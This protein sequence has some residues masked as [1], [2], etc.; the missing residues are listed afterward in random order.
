MAGEETT[1]QQQSN[2]NINYNAAQTG[3]D[4]DKTLGQIP[5]GKLTYALNANV[6]NFDANSVNYQNEEGN[7]FCLE[8]PSGYTLIG[9]HYIQEKAKHIFFLVNSTTGASQI[10]YMVNNDC[11]YHSLLSAECLNFDINYPIH[12]VVHRITNCTTEIYW[13]DGLNARRFLDIDDVPTSGDICNK[14]SVQPN[15][16]I[17]QLDITEVTT[18]GELT[19]GTYQFAIQYSDAQ[20]FGYTSYY[21]VTN[22]TPIA[23]PDITTAEYNYPVNK[24]IRLTISNL[25]TSGYYE[26]YNLAVIKTVNGITSV[27]LIGTYFIDSATNQVTYTGQNQTQIRLSL[28]DIFE[29]FPYYDIAGDVTSVQ[30]ILIWDQLTT[31]KRIDYQSIA[32]Q[33]T[34]QWESYKIPAG[35]DY[36]NP[37]IANKLR[38]YLR[39]EVYAFEICFLLKNGRQT[40]GF[41]I[42]GRTAVASDL[43]VINKASNNDYIGSGTSAPTWKI[44]NTA[45]VVGNASQP[46]IAGATAYKYGDFSYWESEEDYQGTVFT[47]A[48]LTGPIRHHKFPDVLV[49]PIFESAALVGGLPV[50]QSSDAV[51]PLGVRVDIDQIKSLIASSSLTT[52]EKAEIVGFKILRGSRSTNKSIVGKGILRN[53]GKYTRE[54][55]DYYFPNYPYNDLNEDPFLLS[56]S[57]AYNSQSV[58]YVISSVTSP[59]SLSYTSCLTGQVESV[60]LTNGM[61][62]FDLCSLT[63]PQLQYGASA[64][65]TNPGPKTVTVGLTSDSSTLFNYKDPDA[66]PQSVNVTYA[67]GIKYIAINSFYPVEYALG[68]KNYTITLSDTVNAMTLPSKLNAFSTDASKFRN[69]FNSPETSFGQP[70]LGSVLKLENA[71]FGESRSHFVQVKNN[72]RYK[73][74]NRTTQQQALQSSYNIAITTGTL[75][76]NAMFTTY[77]AYLQI[78]I[79][80]LSRTNFAY[81]FNSTASYD[82]W[83]NVTNSGNKQRELS[84]YQYLIPGVQSTADD[85]DVNN[86]QRESSVYLKTAGS[87]PLPFVKD[88]P[89]VSSLSITDTTRFTISQRHNCGAPE[90]IVSNSSVMYYASLKNIVPN[91]YGQLYSYETIDTGFQV[92][93]DTT[94]TIG[95]VFGGDTFVSRFAFKTKLPFFI[96]NRVGAPDDSDIFYDEVGNIAYPR[97]WHSAR[98]ILSNYQVGSLTNLQNII[99]VKATALDCPNDPIYSAT[100]GVTTTTTTTQSPGN[101]STGNYN[102]GY[103]GKM[104]MFA[105]G[106]PYFYCE[107]SINID[108]RQAVN[109]LDGDFYPHVS[110]GIP[111]TWLQ[112][113]NVPIALDNTYNYNITFSK[114]NTENYF[115]HLPI[116]WDGNN[117]RTV[118]PFRTIYSDP[119]VSDPT[120]K[121]NNWLIYRPSSYFDFPQSYG[122]LISL[123]GIQNKGILARFENKSLMY[124]T[125]LTI[126]TSIPQAAYIGNPTLFKSSPPVDFAETDLGYVGTQNKMLLKIPQGQ[127][128]VDAKRGQIFLLSGQGAV[129]L[130]AFGSGVNRF[131]TDHMAFEIL[132]YYP[133]A[134]IDNSYKG[135]GLS[136]V[137][138]SKYDRVIITKLDYIPQPD[139]VGV[140]TYN[141]TTN[142]F[143]VGETVVSLTDLTYF[144]NRSW[145]LSFN[146]NTKSWV[147]FH[148]YLPNYY[149]GD[150]NFY[151]SG[152]VGVGM[153]RHLTNTLLNNN[154]YGSIAP[155]VIEYPFMYQYH[156]EI[157]QNVKDYTRAYQ[158][159][160]IPDGVYND[161]AKIQTDNYYF[162]KAVLYNGQQSTGLLELVKK[163]MHNLAAYNQYPIYNADS[164]TI[165]FTKS[166]SFY[167]YNTFW[168]V[169][170]DKTQPLFN[171]TCES[172]SIDKAINQS[173]MDYGTRSYR[174]DPL[175]AKGLLV[176]HILDDR[177]DIHL[178]S[179][180]IVAPS[181][182]SY[183]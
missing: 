7:E 94:D 72:A 107:S 140:I 5:R 116:D 60:A 28:N 37:E 150:N 9:K 81:S 36:S 166:D 119:Q 160:P 8:F 19:A 144:C 128:S 47:A 39:D 3:I 26:Y 133:D 106:I 90:D 163:P 16:N 173:N 158:Y 154:Y 177:S 169:V 63:Y 123:D 58:L 93:L 48:G 92:D 43:V 11:V 121:V 100:G 149:I 143:Y 165:L 61:A 118:Y 75:D 145:T 69:V 91:Q 176:R 12:K 84:I 167:N 122:D 10:G 73:L 113:S 15:F 71:I 170:K 112:Q 80:G 183:K 141:T 21:S 125:M 42:P 87:S 51:Y 18:G 139:Y 151:Y 152:K 131:M 30:D 111:D 65:I 147:S 76:G 136:G 138:D 14:L 130:T 86:F 50:T 1:N 96:D 89:A 103:L 148:T 172:L 27:E 164:K 95:V 171:I 120:S 162:N 17:P 155:Y 104:Y 59:G 55:T 40:D 101:V 137:Y 178:V 181:Q 46:N 23:N 98:S 108:L 66:N 74:I 34:L 49:S 56:T 4:M 134:Q 97:Y 117:C 45:T 6:E 109:N 129:D 124:N 13:T 68:S 115:S 182:I 174:K 57:N 157:L 70:S 79:N 88:V 35:S 161:N 77:Q 78:Y 114:Q 180:F 175:R 105:Y 20:G 64:A 142:E 132:R 110:S 62:S 168:N 127:I 53:V 67:D 41:H 31:N 179:Q 83:A 25:E 146:M 38:G 2:I 29:K 153:W 22:P 32:A 135:L 102:Y 159:L 99:S 126:N 44:Y 82:Y 85:H 156:D 24:S 33:I 54:G 52:E